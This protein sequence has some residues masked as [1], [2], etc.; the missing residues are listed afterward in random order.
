MDVMMSKRP[1][2]FTTIPKLLQWFGVALVLVLVVLIPLYLVL[3][4]LGVL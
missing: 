3:K 4:L 2:M 1:G